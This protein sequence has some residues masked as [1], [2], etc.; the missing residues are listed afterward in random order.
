MLPTKVPPVCSANA[1][2]TPVRATPEL[3][4]RALDANSRGIEGVEAD[5][6]TVRLRDDP[7]E[8]LTAAVGQPG[9]ILHVRV[10]CRKPA[11]SDA[12]SGRAG[13]FDAGKPSALQ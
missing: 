11:A 10:K 1:W 5:M 2:Q 7:E 12:K 4:T 3:P 8:V 9:V 13:C 6:V